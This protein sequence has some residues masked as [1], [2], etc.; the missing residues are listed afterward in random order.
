M[1]IHFEIE[2]RC[3]LKCR[4]CSSFA[5]AQGKRMDYTTKE[6]I[7]FLQMFSEKKY[8]FLTGGEPLLYE[9]FD[10]IIFS[11]KNKLSNV[12]IG[13]FTTGIVAHQGEL[14]GISEKR[15]QN[16]AS[17][18]LEICYFSIYS[19]Q[20]KKHDWMTENEGSFLLTLESIKRLCEQ[21]VEVR[22]NLVITRKNQEE[23]SDIIE[24]ASS[25]DCAEVRLL[26]LVNHGRAK[27][28]WSDIGVAEQEFRNIVLE[29]VN[30]YKNI[31]ITASSCPDILPCRPFSDAQG[32]QAGSKLAYVT[33]EGNVFPCACATNSECYKIGKIDDIIRLKQY[34]ERKKPVNDI[35][36]CK[37]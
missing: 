19:A 10:D 25:L 6:M 36:L 4:H 1:E 14:C 26:K 7:A 23:I 11:L 3:L 32:C 9:E 24:M 33:Y 2:N 8:V 13:A 29:N 18:G 20:A 15:A 12:S 5:T 27:K 21:D 31:K 16:L 30:R 17:L 28:C 22:I 35:A 37:K 34:F